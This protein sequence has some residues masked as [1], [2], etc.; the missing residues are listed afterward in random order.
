MPTRFFL[1]LATLLF[2]SA[3]RAEQTPQEVDPAFSGIPLAQ[4]VSKSPFGIPLFAATLIGDPPRLY[5]CNAEKTERATLIYYD[6]EPINT[7]IEIDVEHV[8]ARYVNCAQP[9]A[10]IVHFVSGRGITLGMRREQVEK[11]LG[12]PQ[13][14]HPQ[15]DEIVLIYRLDTKTA[16]HFLQRHDARAYFGQYH[17]RQDKLVRFNYGFEL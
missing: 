17:F 5:V 7:L 12:K 9:H 16:A 3:A 11:I 2:C 8:T 1:L 13:K 6:D 15:L 4:A 14:T 10:P